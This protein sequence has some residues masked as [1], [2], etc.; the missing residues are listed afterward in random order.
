MNCVTKKCVVHIMSSVD[1]LRLH[2]RSKDDDLGDVTRNSGEEFDIR[3]C[4]DFLRRSRFSCNFY[5]ESKQ[6]EFDVY[7]EAPNL[8][9]AKCNFQINYPNLIPTHPHSRLQ[10]FFFFSRRKKR[11]HTHT[12]HNRAHHHRETSSSSSHRLHPYTS[13]LFVIAAVWRTN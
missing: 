1:N 9:G 10:F 11:T 13:L 6:Q 3:F 12:I 2:C 4:L 5:W 7:T 8:E